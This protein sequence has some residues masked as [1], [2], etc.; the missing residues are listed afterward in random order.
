MKAIC[1][2]ILNLCAF[3]FSGSI[4]AQANPLEH[5]EVITPENGGEMEQLTIL[6]TRDHPI[7]DVAFSPDG[8][9]LAS[10]NFDGS[11]VLWNADTQTERLV[12]SGQ[13]GWVEAVAFSPDDNFLASGGSAPPWDSHVRL[14]DAR[15]GELI[16]SI[17]EP[18]PTRQVGQSWGTDVAFSPDDEF[19]AYGID[20]GSHIGALYVWQLD[21]SE[22]REILVSTGGGVNVAFSPDGELLA[23]GGWHRREGGYFPVR[24]WNMDAESRE[25]ELVDDNGV[26]DALEFSSS[27]E[28]LAAASMSIQLW[29]MNTREQTYDLRGHRWDVNTISFNPDDTLLASG[30]N[31]ETIRL[32]EVQTGREI[33]IG[34]QHTDGVTDVEFN[35]DGTILA[36]ASRDG[37]IRLWGIPSP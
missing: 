18:D 4:Y 23:S 6:D 34:H 15:S 7:L 31:D 17:P 14:W 21:P 29:D 10:A 25:E 3:V 11:I 28:L 22:I 26:V 9:T 13:P 32:W 24:L 5:L 19:I 8:Q 27:G 35:P 20:H 16:A 2:F 37:T 33:A 30:G 1:I 12:L 36:S